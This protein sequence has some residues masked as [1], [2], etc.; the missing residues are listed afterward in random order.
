[1]TDQGW[2]RKSHDQFTLWG[3]PF[4]FHKETDNGKDFMAGIS[5]VSWKVYS[6]KKGE[7]VAETM[8]DD[9]DRTW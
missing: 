7:F 9:T 1:M 3:Q 8:W 5:K 6:I 4:A 2:E